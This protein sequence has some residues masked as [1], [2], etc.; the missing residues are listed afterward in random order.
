MQNSSDWLSRSHP[1]KSHEKY[2][3]IKPIRPESFTCF[4]G[5]DHG[6]VFYYMALL[7]NTY[8]ARRLSL[9]WNSI[10]IKNETYKKFTNLHAFH[11]IIVPI[12]L[13]SD[14]NL[15]SR[16]GTP[17]CSFRGLRSV[18]G[19]LRPI[20]KLDTRTQAVPI[21]RSGWSTRLW[22]IRVAGQLAGVVLVL[23][24]LNSSTY[25]VSSS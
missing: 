3:K 22:S 13:H 7:K 1:W 20:P 16:R 14:K 9:L 11:L 25:F 15:K 17:I 2:L 21:G 10:L 23:N 19:F 24:R 6:L 12:P 18:P 5:V 8:W 4:S